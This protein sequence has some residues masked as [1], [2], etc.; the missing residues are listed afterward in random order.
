MGNMAEILDM[1]GY[2]LYV[3]PSFIVAALIMLG[4][5][6]SSLRSLRRAQKALVHAQEPSVFPAGDET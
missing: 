5:V 1:G 3:W 4:M 2:A 6:V